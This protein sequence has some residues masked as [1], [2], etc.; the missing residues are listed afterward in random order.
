MTDVAAMEAA[1]LTWVRTATGWPE[2]QVVLAAEDGPRPPAPSARVG[3]AGPTHVGGPDEARHSYDSG[4]AAGSEIVTA[5][6]GQRETAVTV[7]VI[8]DAGA[9]ASAAR[10]IA[11]QIATAARL[12]TIAAGFRAADCSLI[13]A[14][15]VRAIPDVLKTGVH[16]RAVLEARFYTTTEAEERAGYIAAIEATDTTHSRVVEVP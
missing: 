5:V 3:I 10:V 7:E 11:D 8:T 14:G 15:P 16:G 9:G 13:E 2:A 1:L 4:G 12:P 6:C